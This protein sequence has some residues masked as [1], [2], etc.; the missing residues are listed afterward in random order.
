[1]VRSGAVCLAGLTC[2]PPAPVQGWPL[3]I[4]VITPAGGEPVVPVSPSVA[5]PKSCCRLASMTEVTGCSADTEKALPYGPG[6]V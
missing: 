3:Q 5:G 2:A 4:A 6:S 1:M